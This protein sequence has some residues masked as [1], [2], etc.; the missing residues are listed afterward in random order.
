MASKRSK[1]KSAEGSDRPESDSVY[2]FLYHDARRVGSFLGQFDPNGH[3]Q[4]VQT[5]AKIGRSSES[6]AT[7]RLS[8]SVPL[9]VT[10][11]GDYEGKDSENWDRGGQRTF[12]PLWGNALA[13][14]DYLT[15]RDLIVRDLKTAKIGQFILL[16]GELSIHDFALIKSIWNS[17]ELRKQWIENRKTQKAARKAVGEPDPEAGE[18]TE[19][20]TAMVLD[21]IA[22]IPHGTHANLKT[23]GNLELWGSLK[24]EGMTSAP[25]DLVLTHGSQV[26]GQWSLLGILD[27]C[28]DKKPHEKISP[29]NVEPG[30][31]DGLRKVAVKIGDVAR[32]AFGRSPASY[33]VT[34]LLIF[35]E[36]SGG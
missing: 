3:L 13:F 15:Q 32:K 9:V 33:G 23:K 29:L 36:V 16:G 1:P 17:P 4:G 10:A 24:V 27:A 35:R 19:G 21:I 6:R 30:D 25:G 26:A 31:I 28:P 20:L 22:D 5:T 12:D 18:T 11:A 7:M 34:P 14:L 8:G 2:D